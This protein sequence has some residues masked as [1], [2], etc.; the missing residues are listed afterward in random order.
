M[1]YRFVGGLCLTDIS[2][3]LGK[4]DYLEVYFEEKAQ[5][6]LIKFFRNKQEFDTIEFKVFADDVGF[7]SDIDIWKMKCLD[8]SADMHWMEQQLLE[9]DNDLFG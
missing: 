1:N 9:E 3:T 6:F 7:L 5:R 2:P 8:L 4:C